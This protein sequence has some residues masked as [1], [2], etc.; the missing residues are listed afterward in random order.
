MTEQKLTD[1]DRSEKNI[2]LVKNMAHCINTMTF[3]LY[4]IKA[5]TPLGKTVKVLFDLFGHEGKS[6][7]GGTINLSAVSLRTL[8]NSAGIS[9]E[10][11][12]DSLDCLQRQKV[13]F[14]RRSPGP[15]R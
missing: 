5:G 1:R 2:Q 9:G 7:P 8:A 11:L 14:Y 12:Q 10:E 3:L 15:G 4:E 13:I 6:S